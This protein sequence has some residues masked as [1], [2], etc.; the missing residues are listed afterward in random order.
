MRHG[1]TS[2][3]FRVAR[4]DTAVYV[5]LAEEPGEEMTVEAAVHEELRR[6]GVR[7]P[8]VIGVESAQGPLGRGVLVLSE[9]PG[10]PII[11]ART[12]S[13]EAWR[14]VAADVGRD[15][16]R[17]ASIPVAG[18]GFVSR[19][20]YPPLSAPVLSAAEL[21]VGPAMDTLARL[22]VSSLDERLAN[23]A[24]TLIADNSCL[25]EGT[26]SRLA[27]GDLDAT[28]IYTAD[29]CYTGIIDFGEMRGAPGL[30]DAAHYALHRGQLEVETLPSLLEGYGQIAD[31]PPEP[32]RHIA[33]LGT[34]IG[35]QLLDL[36]ANR[37]QHAYRQTLR[38]GL[39]R[40][41]RIA[42]P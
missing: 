11:E 20:S 4:G 38:D 19:D 27:H 3:V 28:H 29:G 24:A 41:S 23:A 7:L 22:T 36:T 31:L 30:Y 15:L 10:R 25:L 2:V 8:A 42:P 35:L 16:A 5:R 12:R 13:Q 18:F 37:D 33:L 40:L 26:D 17:I 1:G 21:L 39:R 14:A 34:L 32:E 9:M 6:L